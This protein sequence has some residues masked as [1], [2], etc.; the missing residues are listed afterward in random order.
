MTRVGTNCPYPYVRTHADQFRQVLKRVKRRYAMRKWII[1]AKDLKNKDQLESIVH[2]LE[3]MLRQKKKIHV[4]LKIDRSNH[5]LRELV[6]QG[7]VS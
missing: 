5:E 7:S 3:Q 6:A 4:V 1:Y 2:F